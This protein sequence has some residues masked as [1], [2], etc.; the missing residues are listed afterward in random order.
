MKYSPGAVVAYTL[1]MTAS[2]TVATGGQAATLQCGQ[3][4]RVVSGDTLSQISLRAYDSLVYQPIYNANVGVIGTNPDMIYIGQVLTIPCLSQ[5]GAVLKVADTIEIEAP[6]Q[7]DATAVGDRLVFTFNKA[8]APPFIINSGI[9]DQYLAEI[10][11]V[12]EGRVTFVDPEVMNR[13]HAQQFDLVTSGEVDAAYVLNSHLAETHPLLQ[14]P[15]MPM[16]GGSAEQTAVSLWRV[17]AEY[18]SRSDYFPEAQLLGFISAPAAHI[19]RHDSMP[20]DVGENIAAANQYHVPYF[21]GLDTRGPAAMRAEF[22]D[23]MTAY[24]AQSNEPPAFFMAHGAALAVGLWNPTTN[25]SVME[26]DNGL[27]TPTFSV[28]LSN[29]AWAQISPEDQD[30]IRAVSGEKLAHRSASWDMFDNGFRSKMLM[31]GLKFTKADKA[32]LHELWSSSI[33]DLKAWVQAAEDR[34]IPGNEAI[35]YYLSSLRS[36]ED[37]LIYR[38]EETYVDQ[39]PFVTLGN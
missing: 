6:D 14:L 12:T 1:A 7:D 3:D 26:V 36:L 16:F 28:I 22:S 23:W 8:S 2:V 35:T 4:Y 13:D 39:N 29:D 19:W 33:G 30:A 15:M 25:V 11:E 37:R 5:D 10:A 32:L 31:D 21:H 34:G 9:V 24:T 27:Y 17:H 18:L 38:G 20:V